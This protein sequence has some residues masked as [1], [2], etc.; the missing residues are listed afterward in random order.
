MSAK[1]TF[2]TLKCKILV[3]KFRGLEKK[4]LFCG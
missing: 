4:S 2:L 1:N 3:E